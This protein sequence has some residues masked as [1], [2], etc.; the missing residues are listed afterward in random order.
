MARSAPPASDLILPPPQP[1][2]LLLPGKMTNVPTDA[3]HG[4]EAAACVIVAHSGE[5]TL[6]LAA[7][8]PELQ[9]KRMRHKIL[10]EH[11]SHQWLPGV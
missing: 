9:D 5:S 3:I 11:A 2:A 10:Q 8:E 4:Q 1:V 7:G 6:E